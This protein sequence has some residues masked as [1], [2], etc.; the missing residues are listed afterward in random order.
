MEHNARLCP[1]DSPHFSV[2][3][4]EQMGDEQR[5]YEDMNKA[6]LEHGF[7]LAAFIEEEISLDLAEE[8]RTEEE[9]EG[10]HTA[11]LPDANASQ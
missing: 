6:A 4:R 10:G 1:S 5:V 3:A 9:G 7:D 11:S 8:Q 2:P